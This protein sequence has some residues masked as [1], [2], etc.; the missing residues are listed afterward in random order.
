MTWIRFIS[1]LILLTVATSAKA[2]DRPPKRFFLSIG[3]DQYRDKFWRPLSFASKDAHDVAQYLEARFDGGWELTEAQTDDGFVDKADIMAAF[4]RLQEVNLNEQDTIVIYFSG[5]GTI[6]ERYDAANLR[7]AIEKYMVTADTDAKKPEASGLSHQELF[8]WFGQLKSRRKVF[9]FDSCYAGSGKSQ[10]NANMLNL[11]AQQKA[12]FFREPFDPLVEGSVFLSASAWGEEA[13]EEPQLKNGIYTHYLL[14]GFDRDFNG[15]GA[16]SITEAHQYATQKVIQDT[17]GSQ[18]P[19]LRMELVGNDPIIINGQRASGAPWLYAYEWLLREF[20]VEISGKKL[21]A[22]GKGGLVVPKGNQHLR[23]KN[24]QGKVLVDRYVEFQNGQEYPLSRFLYYEPRYALTAGLTT[25]Q[26]ISDSLQRHLAPQVI[27]GAKIR[28]QQRDLWG[29]WDADIS[30]SY[31]P[32]QGMAIDSQGLAVNQTI[33]LWDLSFGIAQHVSLSKTQLADRYGHWSLSGRGAL[34][35][36][37][38]ERQIADAAF[39]EPQQSATY[40]GLKSSAE[41]RYKWPGSQYVTGF[42]VEGAVYRN[43]FDFGPNPFTSYGLQ[44]FWG[45]LW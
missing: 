19:S 13:R 34:S 36:Q 38:L 3:V 16:V 17:Q 37:H 12:P 28:A 8:T 39:T 26:P 6:G 18:H 45:A 9:I 20:Q 33:Q 1:V 27:R 31:Y 10:L 23:V 5:H 2:A 24:K 14:E 35:V 30:L 7:R 4:D 43:T 25:F 11:L 42:T 40:P 22:L 32:D 15:D 21:G 44:I 41:L 29:A